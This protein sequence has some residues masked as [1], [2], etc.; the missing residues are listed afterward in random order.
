MI[1]QDILDL[2]RQRQ[3]IFDSES[4]ERKE[5]RRFERSMQQAPLSA[6]DFQTFKKNFVD[7]YGGEK[8]QNTGMTHSEFLQYLK[9]GT[10]EGDRQEISSLREFLRNLEK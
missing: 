8:I 2:I 9:D 4:K 10:R 7:K 6:D 5:R 1:T 3:G